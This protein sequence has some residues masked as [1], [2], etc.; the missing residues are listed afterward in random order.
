MD[1]TQIL[2]KL[3]ILLNKNFIEKD[4]FNK[5]KTIKGKTQKTEEN[6]IDVIKSTLDELNLKYIRASSQQSKDFRIEEPKINLEI[7]KLIKL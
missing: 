4:I 6:Y 5:C 7:K 3:E 2:N 1:K